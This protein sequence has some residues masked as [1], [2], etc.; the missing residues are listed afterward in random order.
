MK[1]MKSKKET[2]EFFILLSVFLLILY[3]PAM[4]LVSF[5]LQIAVFRF[6]VGDDKL[7][8]AFLLL[9][10]VPSVVYLGGVVTL[11]VF[12]LSFIKEPKPGQP[13]IQ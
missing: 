8:T 11:L 5:V 6:F 7:M 13:Q 9:S 12:A 3:L 4:A 1:K 10:R 2:G